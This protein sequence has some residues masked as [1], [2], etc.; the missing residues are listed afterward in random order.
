V[1]SIDHLRGEEFPV[2][3]VFVLTLELAVSLNIFIL[4][5][6]PWVI[7][8]AFA[9]GENENGTAVLPP[10]LAGE[11]TWR[12][13]EED[14]ADEQKN[15]GEHLECPWSAESSGTFDERATI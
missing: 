15:G 5:C 3:N 13:R 7:R 11:P 4:P 12:F 10:V 8:I 1:G 2:S 9:V 6:D 14:H